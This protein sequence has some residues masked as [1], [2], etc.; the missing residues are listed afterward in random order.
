MGTR[1]DA[2]SCSMPERSFGLF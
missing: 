2:S 1:Q